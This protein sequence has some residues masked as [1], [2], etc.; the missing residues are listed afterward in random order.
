MQSRFSTALGLPVVEEDSLHPLGMIDGILLHPDTGR[1][2]GFFVAAPGFF[3]THRLFLPVSAICRWSRRVTV[4]DA[5]SLAPLDEHVRLARLADDPRNILG[6]RIITEGGRR[7]GV[8]ADVQF[9]TT[10]FQLQWLFPKKYLLFWGVPVPAQ[11]IAEVRP[12]AILVREQTVTVANSAPATPELT[13]TPP[14]PA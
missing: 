6:Q 4:R 2:E 3:S 10:A 12:D 1:V 11:T 9:D 13:V 8:C 5:D 7:L 14:T